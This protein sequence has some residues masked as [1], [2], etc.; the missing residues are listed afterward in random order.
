MKIFVL[1]FVLEQNYF[2]LR[3]LRFEAYIF[4]WLKGRFLRPGG[5][6]LRSALIIKRDVWCQQIRIP[7]YVTALDAVGM[8]QKLMS[9]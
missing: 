5:T 6:V 9:L 2:T 1:I 7:A 4:V 3:S 8:K